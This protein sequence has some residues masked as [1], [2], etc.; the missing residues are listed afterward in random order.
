MVGGVLAYIVLHRPQLI[1]KHKDAQSFMGFVLI[2]AGLLLLNKGRDFPGWWALLPTLGAFF[3]ISAGPSS[4]LNEKLLANKPMVWIG[5]ISYPLYL[6]HWPI[7]SY[8]RISEG[9]FTNTQGLCA[10]IAAIGLA[11]LTYHL[12]EKP[13]RFGGKSRVKVTV[14][15]IAM[16]F[17]LTLGAM[18]YK[19]GGGAKDPWGRG[20][21]T[22]YILRTRYLNGSI[23]PRRKC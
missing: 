22:Y 14:L 4:W 15:L 1:E 10:L 2:L 3:I 6:W 17:V 13:F 12:L 21:I 7:L 5:L 8:I 16:V 19:Q 23:F 20:V 9:D 18:L 11:W